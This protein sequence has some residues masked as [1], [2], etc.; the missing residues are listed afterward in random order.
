MDW[1]H[2]NVK[3]LSQDYSE[4]R[5]WTI[6]KDWSQIW[7]LRLLYKCLCLSLCFCDCLCH[8]H[9][10]CHCLFIW[11]IIGNVSQQCEVLTDQLTRLAPL[12]TDCPP[13][14][15]FIQ[16]IFLFFLNLYKFSC[17][18]LLNPILAR[19]GVKL[20]TSLSSPHQRESSQPQVTR[21]S[22]KG[23]VSSNISPPLCIYLYLY[24]YIQQMA[25]YI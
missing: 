5:Q 25:V 22:T 20:E 9:C 17:F 13:K 14:Q 21:E 8:C 6:N 1:K 11:Q 24:L 18:N 23:Q 19:I 4:L 3:T 16:K 12:I 15:I 2:D 10:Q 7:S